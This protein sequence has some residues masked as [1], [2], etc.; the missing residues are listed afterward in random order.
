MFLLQIVR[1]DGS[2]VQFPG[3]GPL[4]VE[5]IETATAAIVA[6]GV[7]VGKS[8]AHVADDIRAGLTETIYALKYNTKFV[9][10]D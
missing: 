1:P 4:E 10:K 3:G 2:V 7:G 5:F 9:T 8:E 6:K